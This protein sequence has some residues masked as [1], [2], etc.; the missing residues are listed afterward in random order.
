MTT[1]KTKILNELM[2]ARG[3][4]RVREFGMDTYTLIHLKWIADKDLLYSTGTLLIV[5]WP[6]AWEGSW[7]ECIHVY[8]WLGPF[9]VNLKLS[10]HC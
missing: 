6:L 1:Y 7:G 4:G 8:V 5:T 3:Q 2:V 10:Q 9:A